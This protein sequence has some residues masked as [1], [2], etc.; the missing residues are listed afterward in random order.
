MNIAFDATALLGPMSKNRGIGNYSYSQLKKM[1]EL[2]QQNTYYFFNVFEEFYM[3]D[4][5]TEGNI[6]DA[7]FFCGK[8]YELAGNF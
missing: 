4:H 5:V 8:N 7:C 1:I 6:V 2:D 3:E